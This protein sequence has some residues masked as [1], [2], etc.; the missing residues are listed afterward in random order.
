[1]L[2]RIP[3]GFLGTPFFEEIWPGIRAAYDPSFVAFFEGMDRRA[4]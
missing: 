3:L 2:K 1:M 4:K